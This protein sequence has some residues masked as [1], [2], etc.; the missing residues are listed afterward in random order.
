MGFHMN[1]REIA[2]KV[3]QEKGEITIHC[4]GNSMR[5]IIAPKEAIHL[6]RVNHSLIRVGDAVF[7]R[8]NGG[9]Q[10]HKVSAIQNENDYDKRRF[11]ISNNHGHVNGWIGG[12]AIFG[13][14]V[15][16][17]DRVLVSNE[18]LRKRDAEN[19]FP[20]SDWKPDTDSIRKMK[21]T[22]ELD[23][24]AHMNYTPYGSHGETIKITEED[25][26]KLCGEP[27]PLRIV[28]PVKIEK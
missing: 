15:G 7:C 23:L 13:L 3:L 25:A 2:I 1:P 10:V 18:E 21:E 12:H 24:D 9:L 20:P 17:E 28:V 22:P 14:A 11:Q 5:P 19:D 16:I 4:N 27:K 26:K 8:I 6:K